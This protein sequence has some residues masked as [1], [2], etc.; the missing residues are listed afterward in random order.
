MPVTLICHQTEILRYN[1]VMERHEEVL[2][3][4]RRIIRAI[5]LQSKSL[6]QRSGLTGP[7][8]LLLQAVARMGEETAGNLAKEISLSQGTVTS[9]LDRLERRGLIR[10]VRGDSDKRKVFVSLSD[11]GREVL[12]LSPTL[13]Q[14]HFI[15]SFQGLKE[16]EQSLVV[17][18]LQRVAEMMQ[19]QDLDA[20]PMLATTRGLD[21]VPTY[22]EERDASSRET[23]C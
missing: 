3:A 23:R 10:R 4:L 5:D 22:G 1:R 12:A 14:E 11:H 8:L 19:A 7:Q 6:M 2:I 13:L 9:I 18:T 20:A 16:W 21:D 17:S 15:R